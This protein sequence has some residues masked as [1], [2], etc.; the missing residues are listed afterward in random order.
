MSGLLL[1]GVVL[2]VV[3]GHRVSTHGVERLATHPVEE[4]SMMVEAGDTSGWHATCTH[5]CID[6]CVYV[7]MYNF[8]RVCMYMHMHL[9]SVYI[10]ICVP[11]TYTHVKEVRV[12]SACVWQIQPPDAYRNMVLKPV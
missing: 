7:H 12:F 4:Q 11:C 8:V 10:C 2:G 3:L 5:T 1:V 6:M 9:E